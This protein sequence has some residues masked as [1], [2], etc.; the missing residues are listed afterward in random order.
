VA[1]ELGMSRKRLRGKDN[2][3]TVS[4]GEGFANTK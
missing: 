3:L 1:F 4:A 2:T